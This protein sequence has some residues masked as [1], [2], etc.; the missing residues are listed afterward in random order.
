LNAEQRRLALTAA[1]IALL[2]IALVVV[3]RSRRNRMQRRMPTLTN[4]R[5]EPSAGDFTVLHSLDEARTM[6]HTAVVMLGNG[7]IYLTVPA[8]HVRC[9][10]RSLRSLL[11]ALDAMGC[12]D[13]SST[14]LSFE[15]APIGSGVAHDEGA[16]AVVDG[17]WLH[18]DF[19]DGARELAER[20]IF[21]T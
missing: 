11:W 2:A 20:V 13:P 18:P 7:Q 16:A 17:I 12:N 5:T 3:R 1:A 15:L 4:G 14:A 10:E 21:G 9:D 8:K 6:E 19:R